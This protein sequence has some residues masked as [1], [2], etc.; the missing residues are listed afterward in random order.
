MSNEI[1]DCPDPLPPELEQPLN[2][3]AAAWAKSH[4]RPRASLTAMVDWDKL[5]DRWVSDEKLPLFVRK[6]Q[7]ET[8]RGQPVIHRTGRAL[9][10]T[11][12]SPAQWAFAMAFAGAKPNLNE[13][14]H[15]LEAGQIPMAMIMGSVERETAVYRGLRGDVPNPNAH[16][17]KVCHKDRVRLRGRGDITE[18]PL[19]HL[20]DHFKRFLAPSNMFLVPKALSGLG[21]LPQFIEAIRRYKFDGNDT[22]QRLKLRT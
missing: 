3:L 22:I 1:P 19:E 17:W 8:S 16:G 9:I 2:E 12:N 7:R 4:H 10:P 11:D 18:I 13:I 15:L 5:L 21:E 6:K 20:K 14:H